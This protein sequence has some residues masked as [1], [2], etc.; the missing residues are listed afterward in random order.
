MT[1]MMISAAKKAGTTIGGTN[2]DAEVPTLSSHVVPGKDLEAPPLSSRRAMV[3][4]GSPVWSFSLDRAI[5]VMWGAWPP[6]TR[7]DHE[8]VRG[9]HPHPG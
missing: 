8:H 9:G 5:V 1:L 4:T 6:M 7:M 3:A 2:H